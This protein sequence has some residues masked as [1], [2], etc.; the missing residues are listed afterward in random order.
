MDKPIQQNIN[1]GSGTKDHRR[2]AMI[3][4]LVVVILILAA[5][6][7]IKGQFNSSDFKTTGHD[8]TEKNFSK[9]SLPQSLPMEITIEKIAVKADFVQLGLQQDGTIQ[10]PSKGSDVGWYKYGPTPG[11]IGPSVVVGHLDIPQG[12][13]IFYRLNELQ[14]D[15]MVRIKRSDGK[16]AVFRVTSKETYSQDNFPSQKV[17]GSIDY[18]GLRLITCHGTYQPKQG[19]YSDNLVVYAELD[20]IE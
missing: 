13:A 18:P 10:V 6:W 2:R 9:L 11:E 7:V 17:Y 16:T 20:R 4:S 19:H 3:F 5:A 1:N 12:P 14:K 8:N 15:D